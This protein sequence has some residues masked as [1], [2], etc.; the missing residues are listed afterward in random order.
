MKAVPLGEIAEIISGATPKSNV[1]E[2]WGGDVRWVTPADLSK[3][4]G[5]YIADTPRTI[6]SAGLASC[7][8][9]VLPIGS[10]LLSSR[11][12]IGHVAINTEPM[13]TNQGFKSFVPRSSHLDS[14]Y[15]YH[16]LRSSTEFL[17]SL[18]NGATFKELS[19]AT[20]GRVEIPLPEI[21]EQKRI[22]AI[23][24]LADEICIKRVEV[25]RH[26]STLVASLL[27]L[28]LSESDTIMRPIGD[29]ADVRSGSTPDR[30]EPSY[31]GGHIP[32]LKTAEVDGLIMNT[33]EHVTAEGVTA[34]RLRVFPAGS[35]V[36][37]MY[38]QGRTRGKSA[39]LGIPA[40][41]NQACAVISP[42]GRFNS[43]FLQACLANEYET[44]RGLGRGGTQP[45]L[46]LR[47]IQTFEVPY[48]EIRRQQ[49]F[50]GR[51]ALVEARRASVKL[52]IRAAKALLASLRSRAFRG[53]L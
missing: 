53:E 47:L 29:F 46:N 28:A 11:A 42:N 34:A 17:Q 7:A 44:L 2:Y 9:S 3:L 38:G 51:I 52:G 50:A 23:L 39:I 49:E 6:T 5:A 13:A 10:V 27:N 26:L 41:T 43:V 32:W 48:I 16:W 40:A 35:V 25:D 4:A 22:A 15:L 24:D 12:P 21:E 20:V 45:N 30:S 14:K 36:I 37:A 1:A 19:K 33:E 31:F 8:A 18:G